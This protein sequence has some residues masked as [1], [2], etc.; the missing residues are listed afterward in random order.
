[1]NL[2]ICTTP[3]QSLI[4]NA[5][6]QQIGGDFIGIYMVYQDNEKQQYYAKKLQQSCNNMQYIV[7]KNQDMKAQFQT[8]SKI[9]NTLKHLNIYKKNID[10]IYIASIDLLFIQYILARVNYNN[11][12]TFDDGTAN[13]FKTSIYYQQ[14]NIFTKQL[15][16]LLIGIKDSTI[17]KIKEKSQKH[18]TIFKEYDNIIANTEFIP[19]FDYQYS[20]SKTIS[21]TQT[22]KRILLGQPF[23]DILG[24]AIY[25]NMVVAVMNNFAIDEFYPHPRERVDFSE[26]LT[27]I[28]SEKI[29]EDYII[30]EL[31]KNQNLQFEI[32]SFNSTA[33]FSLRAI[34]R[35]DI[36][37]VF[38]RE[39]Q[40]CSAD[41]DF[42]KEHG[43][44]IYFT[45]Y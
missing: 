40:C 25:K 10:N 39:L 1:M 18:Y 5:L 31:R 15:F 3:L 38:H 6:I 29:I 21:N 36:R 44:K 27:V 37:V 17:K 7:L 34:E 22:I 43:F 35:V 33:I 8:L 13:L 41:Y 26:I 2:I 9:K 32:Y 4:A 19:L 16:K 42:L 11:L 23:D 14:K 20:I 30:S 45:D 24:R 12:F 28:D